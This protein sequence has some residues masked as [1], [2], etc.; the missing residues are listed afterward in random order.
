MNI[1]II[2]P[3]Y[4]PE[5]APIS[6]LLADTVEGLV[7]LGHSVNVVTGI[8]SLLLEKKIDTTKVKF[9]T[10]QTIYGNIY[11][12]P[13]VKRASNRI[14]DKLL[15]YF[16]LRI[17]SIRYKNF[18]TQPD[19]IYAPVPSN[20][21]GMVA[22]ALSKYYKCPYVINVQDI[23]PDAIF[24]LGIVK[25]RFVKAFL[26]YQELKMYRDAHHITVIGDTFKDNLIKKGVCTP[27]SVIPNWIKSSDYE[28]SL[29]T[30][31]AKEWNTCDKFVVLYSGTFGR[32]HGTSVILDAAE[33]L[34]NERDILFLL[35][36]HGAD[37]N[38]IKE[39]VAER[40]LHNVLV[41]KYVPRAK[42]AELQSLSSISLLTM[43]PK[44]GYSS[45][46]SKVLGYMAASRPV[47]AM[48]EEDSDV[49]KL[50]I[51]AQC[52]IVLPPEDVTGLVASIKNCVG[53]Q[54]ELTMWGA[55]GHD[56]LLNRLDRKTLIDQID[57]VLSN[58]TEV[59]HPGR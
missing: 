41:K 14:V 6:H 52:G 17:L 16:R 45:I 3:I 40:K 15:G 46:P 2:T 37:F 39:Q 21:T 27:I 30:D 33:K 22:R 35:V 5:Q 34:L 10:E 55:Q 32:I 8:P 25:N 43:R 38:L 50:I 53:K 54:E 4:L 28:I 13:F 31:L 7:K 1:L 58:V 26:K 49:G 48:T 56:Y 12:L 18:F 20:E 9:C 29:N 51:S 57:Y 47:I 19:V 36:G 23:H 44:L 42:L 11:R 24:N 59:S